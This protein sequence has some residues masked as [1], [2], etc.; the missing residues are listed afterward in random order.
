MRQSKN[1]AREKNRASNFCGCQ[2]FGITQSSLT[3]RVLLYTAMAAESFDIQPSNAVNDFFACSCY[4]MSLHAQRKG[5]NNL[6][7]V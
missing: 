5:I 7:G 6:I 3:R 2:W 4:I 1:K